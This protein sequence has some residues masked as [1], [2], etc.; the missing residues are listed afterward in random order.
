MSQ[1]KEKEQLSIFLC[2]WLSV[3]ILFIAPYVSYS[4]NLVCKKIPTKVE[5]LLDSIL[6][7]PGS[8][9]LL[10]AQFDQETQTIEADGVEDSVQVCYRVLST[11][12]S[13]TY[14]SR[15]IS[16]YDPSG[17]EST[18]TKKSPPIEKEELFQFSGI[19]KYGAIT[20][21]VSFGNR[22]NLFVNS[23]LN[24]Q[25][26]GLID[27]NLKVSAVITDQNVP[28]QPEGNTQQIRDFDNV[29]I[30]LYN[31]N[32]DITAGDI[33]LQN[34][35]NEG[36]FL[37]YYKN[38]QG[39]QAR[40][41]GGDNEWIHETKVSGAL[42]KG[43]FTSSVVSAIDGLSGPYK[44]R[45]PNGER[46]IIV[47]ANTER[48]FLDG[49]SLQ[50]GFDR[51]YVIDYN[52]GEITFNNHIV[53]TQFS[54]IRID[55]EYSEQFYSRSN[56]SAYQSVERNRTKVFFNYYREKDNP[57]SN[58]GFNLDENDF[59]QLQSIGD[60]LDQAFI[61]GFDSVQFDQNRI[62]YIKKD[63]VDQD[64]LIQNIFE[65]STDE[66]NELFGPTFSEVGLGNGDYQLVNSSANGKIYEWVSPQSGQSQGNYEPGAFIP[67]PNSK[68][69]VSA[70]V[71]IGLTDYESFSSE[72][73]M[74]NTDINLYSN[75]DDGDNNSSGYFAQIKT[76]GRPSFISK[77]KW[78][79]SLSVEY[80]QKDFSFI[81]RY[82]PILFDR[83]WNFDRVNPESN[84]DLLLFAKVGLKKDELNRFLFYVNRRDR[85]NTIDGWQQGAEINQELNGFRLVSTHFHLE[86]NQQIM[87]S[88]WLKSKSD[89]SFGAFSIRPGYIFEIDENTQNERDSVVNSLMHFRSHE[90]YVA[91]RDSSES[92][93]R[94]SYQ[95]REDK[96]PVEGKME[97]YLLSKNFNTRYSKVN[98]NSTASVDLNY[99]KVNDRL[100]LD[101]GEDEI[102]SGR[103][104]RKGSFLK[105]H[106][107]QVFS[108]STGNSR[109]LRREF[110][111]L[112]VNIGEGTHTWRDTNNDGIQDLNEFFEAINPDER[113][114]VKIFTPTDDYITSFQTFY[115]TSVDAKM[116]TKWRKE[117][118]LKL[119]FSKLSA[120]FYY[121]VN[122]KTTSKKFSDR[123]NP[124]NLNLIDE[125]ILSAQNA[126]RYTF[127][128]NRNGRG[129]AGDFT[130]QETDN[131]QLLIQGF[132]LRKR[133]EWIGNLKVDL[134][135][136]Y[137]FRVTTSVSDFLNTSDFLDSRN[138]RINTYSY[139]PQII[140]QPTNLLRVIGS[141]E[142]KVRQNNFTEASEEA[143]SLQNFTTE[144]TWNQA[145]K[146]SLRGSFSLINIDFTGDPSTYLA[147]LLL[148]ALQPGTNQ[149][150]QVNWQQKLS[151]GM[152]LSLLYNGRR[153]ESIKPIHTGSVTITAF[154]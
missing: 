132:E 114:F 30:K 48:V 54:I 66:S 32:F 151:K 82:R 25:M 78:E 8:I 19:Q 121:N 68:Q 70:G 12:L 71:E 22:Q 72:I 152:Q 101:R 137:T 67:L 139:E 38:V 125:S 64:G 136:E 55:F 129:F 115:I 79:G 138:F 65:Y 111:Y 2:R 51:D 49:K 123:L 75:L 15:D 140:W 97:D 124:F 33:V 11:I 86:N 90:F 45:G 36:Y 28:Y 60:N 34:A 56:I 16:T 24:L 74:T 37:K 94:L 128:F 103:F 109:E 146:G 122:F 81:D 9:S 57:N 93:F 127:F 26:E 88:K 96:L 117:D 153:S 77:Y 107:T 141:F 42:S 39:L 23:S 104:N 150:W 112:P 145:S 116:P 105:R 5:V 59:I 53:I 110:I 46:F 118:G 17:S 18:L 76:E 106:I 95:I 113:I 61:T 108:F 134:S 102:L 85:A 21:G 147:Y 43:K 6:I 20:R 148:D 40:Y 84:R 130:Y 92:N 143:T 83:E 35:E 3:S 31:D 154:F 98:S 73:A 44:L 52:L 1:I 119:F 4:Q 41:R 100:M 27:E 80:D 99:R 91:N 10:N 14:S 126:E 63:T 50:R 131:K 13:K 144:I 142:N 47:L 29:F 87:Q 149:T 133:D 58:F 62:L 120:N 69:M 89:L 7:E 135:K